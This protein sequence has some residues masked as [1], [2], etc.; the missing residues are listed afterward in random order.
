MV[1]KKHCR[2]FNFLV[3]EG[4]SFTFG[5]KSSLLTVTFYFEQIKQSIIESTRS[6]DVFKNKKSLTMVKILVESVQLCVVFMFCTCSY[7]ATASTDKW[8]A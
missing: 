4:S 8:T 2:K 7:M 6:H 3:F 1:A 5:T